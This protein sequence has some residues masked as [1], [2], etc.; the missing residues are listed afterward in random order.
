M[1][2]NCGCFV[3][4]QKVFDKMTEK[5]VDSWAT[6][7]DAYAKWDRPVEALKLFGRMECENV[8][9]NE[10]TLVNVLTACAR[11]RDLDMAKR[12]HRYID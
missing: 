10:V 5:S 7:I 1:N 6:M 2:A 3:S 4:A 12:V 11:A 9:L 8:D